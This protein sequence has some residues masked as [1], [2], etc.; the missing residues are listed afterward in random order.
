MSSISNRG[1]ARFGKEILIS[2]AALSVLTAVSASTSSANA[3]AF[4]RSS[5]GSGHS[6]GGHSFGG[7]GHGIGGRSFGGAHSAHVLGSAHAGAPRTAISHVSNANAHKSA[8]VGNPTARAKQS[9]NKPTATDRLATSDRPVGERDRRRFED[10]RVRR[11]SIPADLVVITDSVLLGLDVVPPPATVQGPYT[12]IRAAPGACYD[13]PGCNR[14]DLIA[15]TA[16]KTACLAA[17]GKSFKVIGGT[18]QKL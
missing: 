11:D 7:F 17:G 4:G 1:F 16:D 12:P 5:G 18:C 14:N 2:V 13:K 8:A 15:S 6:M 9:S 3:M 10:H